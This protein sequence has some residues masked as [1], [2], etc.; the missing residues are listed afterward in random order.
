VPEEKA[1]SMMSSPGVVLAK[2]MAA[3]REPRPEFSLV[4]TMIG[5]FEGVIL[6]SRRRSSSLRE[7]KDLLAC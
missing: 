1:K 6:S 2:V 7:V 4:V 3:L 5:E